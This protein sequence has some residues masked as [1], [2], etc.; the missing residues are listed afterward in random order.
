MHR[1]D[2]ER[3]HR[4]SHQHRRRFLR[5][6]LSLA[7]A[8][9]IPRSRRPIEDGVIAVAIDRA[10]PLTFLRTAFHEH[11]WIAVFLKS[12]QSGRVAQRVRPVQQVQS[13]RFQAWLRAENAAGANVYV[14]INAVA[15]LQRSR[16]RNA[17]REIR[18]LFLDADDAAADVLHAIQDTS[19]LPNPSYVLRSSPG[20]AHVFWRVSRFTCDTVEALEKHLARKL[21]TDPA[22]TACTQL[23]R[24]PGFVNHKRAT[25]CL[26]DIDYRDVDRVYE[27][28]DFP[29][30]PPL[31]MLAPRLVKRTATNAVDRARHYVA[32]IPPAVSGQ[33]GDV[34]TFRVCCRVVRGFPLGDDEARDFLRDGNSR[35]EPPGS[36]RELID[37]LSRARRYGR[38]PIGCLLEE[39]P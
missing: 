10:A 22:A 19:E 34:H 31:T 36:D 27:P 39:R 35:C 14:S 9:D 15:P 8:V 33:H 2:A 4:R 37:K 3:R 20:R 23:T 1:N 28:A 25:P 32:A 26:V 38:E 12:Y 17:V 13:P 7:G 24:L 21:G 11:D 29:T 5:R 18:H 30:P 16:R 6:R